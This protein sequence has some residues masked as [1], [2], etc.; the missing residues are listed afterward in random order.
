MARDRRRLAARTARASLHYARPMADD[1]TEQ[2]RRVQAERADR[3][4]DAADEARRP[5][6]ARAHG[7]RSDQ[8]AYLRDK[9]A[10]QAENPDAD[11]GD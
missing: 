11:E 10:E 3:E 1:D 2:L 8:A 4:A 7:R 6:D 9:L 5:E